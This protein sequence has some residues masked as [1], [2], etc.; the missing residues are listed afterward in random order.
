MAFTGYVFSSRKDIAPLIEVAGAGPTFKYCA[1]LATKY[2]STTRLRLNCHVFC[3]YPEGVT[4]AKGVVHF[5]NSQ[6]AVS[7][8]GTLLKSYKKHFLYMTDKAFFAVT[9]IDVGR[10]RSSI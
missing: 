6:M 7:P 1:Q 5:Y 3:G 8:Q 9:R 2:C 4:D 10:R